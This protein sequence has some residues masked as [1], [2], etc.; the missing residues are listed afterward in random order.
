[1]SSL[2]WIKT[3]LNSRANIDIAFDF[4]SEYMDSGLS[5]LY[6]NAAVA[7]SIENKS[8]NPIAITFIKIKM[9]SGE[10][11]RARLGAGFVAH[12]HM[13][14]IHKSDGYD[15]FIESASFPI[16]VG[17]YGAAYE[18]ILFALPKDRDW[19]SICEILVQTNRNCVTIS[20]Q[21]TICRLQE[22]LQKPIQERHEKQEGH[23]PPVET[24]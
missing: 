19:N 16:Q 8:S 6:L 14:G 11:Y 17:P 15:R 4:D 5:S 10:S 12:K 3:F 13:G 21:E 1:M 9:K 22:L 20:D 18:Y 23:Q 7:V 2:S 24:Q